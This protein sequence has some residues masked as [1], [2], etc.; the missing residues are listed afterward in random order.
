LHGAKICSQKQWVTTMKKCFC[1]WPLPL[2][3]FFSRA[4]LDAQTE[5][6]TGVAQIIFVDTL[7]T[8]SRDLAFDLRPFPTPTR[9]RPSPRAAW[10]MEL[11]RF[12]C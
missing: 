2:L 9:Y 11:L 5:V 12:W 8:R 1:V 10:P 7:Q 6:S 3:T 4:L